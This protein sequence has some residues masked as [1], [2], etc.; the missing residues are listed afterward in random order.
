MC[1]GRNRKTREEE[2]VYDAACE[3]EHVLLPCCPPLFHKRNTAQD[4]A[5]DAAYLNQV[6]SSLPGVDPND[7]ALAEVLKQSKEENDGKEDKEGEDK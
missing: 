7:P 3:R 6:L 4:G 2:C 5:M 1:F